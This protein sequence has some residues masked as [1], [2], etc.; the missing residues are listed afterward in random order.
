MRVNT[1]AGLLEVFRQDEHGSRFSE[2]AGPTRWA[3]SSGMKERPVFFACPSLN[4][5]SSLQPRAHGEVKWAS[6]RTKLL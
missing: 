6:I 3:L 4:H 5:A 1:S 2:Q